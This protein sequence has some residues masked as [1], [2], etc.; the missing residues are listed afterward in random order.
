[1]RQLRALAT[2]FDWDYDN[3]LTREASLFGDPFHPTDEVAAKVAHELATGEPWLA[4][5]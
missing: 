3:E 5:H 2:V 1:L 4:K